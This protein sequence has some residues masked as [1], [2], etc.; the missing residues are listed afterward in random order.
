MEI[1]LSTLGKIL[2]VVVA[3]A[4][5]LGGGWWGVRT[6]LAQ[7]APTPTPTPIP[8][9]RETAVASVTAFLTMDVTE[10]Q[11]VWIQRLCDLAGGEDTNGCAYAQIM[12][13]VYWPSVIEGK[14]R[15]G[16]EAQE[17]VLVRDLGDGRQVWKVS[18]MV[19]DLNTGEKRSG[20]L[21]VAVAQEGETW[22]FDHVLLPQEVEALKVNP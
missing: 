16:Y 2:G 21:H 14:K 9:G 18:G 22:R 4:L 17:A 3:V 11:E 6:F 20:D 8:D 10:G 19:T 5:V 13:E 15:L 12:A 7:P 1:K